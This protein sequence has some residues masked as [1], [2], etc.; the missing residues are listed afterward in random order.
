M[1]LFYFFHFFFFLFFSLRSQFSQSTKTE[2][3]AVTQSNSFEFTEDPF[4]DYRYDDPFKIDPFSDT[5]F[6]TD[7]FGDGAF[8]SDDCQKINISDE[9][10][11][12]E[13]QKKFRMEGEKARLEQE[14]A[15]FE[16]ALRL[17]KAPTS[18]SRSKILLQIKKICNMQLPKIKLCMKILY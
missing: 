17:S 15:D 3:K 2:P 7:P 6:E 11:A 4:K 5:G 9:Q 10:L 1:I 14:K 18:D 16:L 8:S 13:A 12:W